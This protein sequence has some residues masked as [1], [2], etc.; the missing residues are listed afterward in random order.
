MVHDASETLERRPTCGDWLSL[1]IRAV[2]INIRIISLIDPRAGAV[3]PEKSV[4]WPGVRA[5]WADVS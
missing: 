4:G 3:I 2:A 5:D 1:D